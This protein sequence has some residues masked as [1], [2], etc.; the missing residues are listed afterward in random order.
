MNREEFNKTLDDYLDGNAADP[1]A[2]EAK[3]RSSAECG[4][5][6][7]RAEELHLRLRNFAAADTPVVT[8]DFVAKALANA[9]QAGAAAERQ[10]ERRQS[11]LTGFG[12]AVAACAALFAVFMFFAGPGG[13]ATVDAP[14]AIVPSVAMTLEEPRTLNL[15]FAAEAALDDAM[16]TVTLP[17]GVA[18]A[19]LEGQRVVT[20]T[21]SLKEGRNVLPLTLIATAAGGGELL[22]KLEHGVDDK[23]FRIELTVA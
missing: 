19:G 18:I 22:A 12:S 23:L 16:L 6:L 1:A 17:A 7:R 8:D 2:F 9:A 14:A 3:A 11:W 15:V 21:T 20:W 10:R 4:D 5:T 13:D